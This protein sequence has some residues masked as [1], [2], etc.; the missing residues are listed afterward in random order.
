MPAVPEIV[1]EGESAVSQVEKH[2]SRQRCENEE[3][4]VTDLFE[5]RY[6]VSWEEIVFGVQS[7][8]EE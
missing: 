1:S 6:D 8:L 3:E 7:C 5:N 4:P 2:C